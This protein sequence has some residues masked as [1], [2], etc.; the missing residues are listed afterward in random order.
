MR[1]ARKSSF[2]SVP[3]ALVIAGVLLLVAP[4]SI[5][6]EQALHEIYQADTR[7]EGGQA[8]RTFGVTVHIEEYSPA[9]ERQTLVDAFQ[10]AGSKGLFNALTKMKSKGVLQSQARSVTTSTSLESCRPRM[11]SRSEC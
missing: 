5:A 11:V 6:Q 7:G 9:D 8:G 1:N 2:V 10:K 3:A 4:H